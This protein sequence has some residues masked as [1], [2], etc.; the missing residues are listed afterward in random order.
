M[1]ITKLFEQKDT[2]F[3]DQSFANKDA[4][5]EFLSNELY[6]KGYV[7]DKDK[8]LALFKERENQASTGIGDHIAMPHIGD[9]I[10]LKNTLVF[11]RTSDL[12]WDSIDNQNIKYIFGIVLSKN[13][14]SSEHMQIMANLSSLLIKADFINKL[15]QIKTAD[16][17]LN[18]IDS[19]ENIQTD[20]KSSDDIYD[21]VAVT[22]CP[23]GIAHTFMAKEKLY[24][25]AKQMNVKIKIE[26]Q[27]ADGI[28]NK[29]T[30][31]D[32]KNAKGVILAVDREIE[33]SRFANSD[34]VIEISTQKAIHKP[35]QQIKKIL[36]KQGNKLQGINAPSN[37]TEAA[38]TFDGFAK[39]M[40]RSLM[41]GISHMLPFIIFGG[42]MLAIAFIIDLIIGSSNGTD[43]NS[44]EFLSSFGFNAPVSNIIF[45]IGKIGL[46]L[47]V[48]ILTA[49]ITF[50]IVGRQGLL[51][52]FVVGAI[53]SGQLAK[54]Y[55]F[56]GESI[57]AAGADADKVLETGSGFIGGI[58]GA[59]F[60][61]AMVIVFAKYVFG[62][63]PESMKGIK[64]I[65][66]MP[67]ISTFAI[68]IIFW[69]VNIV[70]IY[71][72]LGLYLFLKLFESK[73]YLAW[74]LG[75]IIGAMMAV[76]L[77][78]PI[79]KAAYIFGVLSISGG[80]SSIPM[81]AAMAAG[82]VP[83]LGI[84]VSMF[85]TKKLWSKEDRD[86]GKWSSILF[87]LSFISEGAIPYTAKNPKIMIPANIV[88]GVVAGLITA[89]LGVNIIAPHGGIFVI[90]LARSSL[91]GNNIGLSIGLGIVFFLLA[92]IAGSFASAGTIWLASY[93]NK[94]FPKKQKPR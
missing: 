75:I 4:A 61:A 83:P 67:L 28:D 32:I 39:K 23:T 87:G 17:F 66:F 5:L 15:E 77:G 88:G 85:L 57:K 50:S 72:N 44:K 62:K 73:P 69:G 70:L 1:K 14:R 7:S 45:Q 20:S 48:P 56:L 2:I 78:G 26:T 29:L 81:A 52:G 53:A 91:F 30:D 27:G 31:D 36:D 3:F 94:K 74:L 58:L 43:V 24:E 25:Q 37:Q 82:M 84:S 6:Q 92:L 8:A 35:E 71:I 34:N 42:I 16:E 90:F 89:A 47:A 19:F 54:T 63:L 59:F 76:D 21:I 55:G 13:D 10:V 93:I 12:N 80:T 38:M 86:A 46:G 51:P 33:K 11:I 22:A 64:N 65:L 40:Y 68:S 49:Y 41:S 9:D 60:A 18:L 79:N